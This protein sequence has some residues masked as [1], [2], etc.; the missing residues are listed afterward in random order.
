MQA[1][2]EA[3]RILRLRLE[4]LSDSTAPLVDS[5]M[6]CFIGFLEGTRLGS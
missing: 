1:W 5:L 3:P 2:S 6:E 4:E